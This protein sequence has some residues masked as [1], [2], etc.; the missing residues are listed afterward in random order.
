MPRLSPAA[1]AAALVWGAS[2]WA[3]TDPTATATRRVLIQEAQRASEAGDHARALAS[4]EQAGRMEMTASLRRFIAEEQAASGLLAEA[5]GSAD[6][7]VREGRASTLPGSAEHV[8]ACQVMVDALGL[9]AGRVLVRA[10]DAPSDLSVR[11]AGR[12]HAR[13][14]W[15]TAYVVT[16][17]PVEVTAEARGYRPF[18]ALITV[19]EGETREVRV[20]LQALT[21]TVTPG[22]R[23][24]GAGPWAVVGAG[25]AMLGTGAVFFALRGAALDRA[26]TE[27]M[28]PSVAECADAPS[29]AAW[30]RGAAEHERAATWA[31]LSGVSFALG[32]AATAGG[33]LWYILAPREAAPRRVV[34]LA[35]TYGGA[36]VS[37]GGSL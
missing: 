28:R 13:T 31:A 17:G 10:T 9:R 22:T 7:C 29:L 35:L 16:P 20:V 18:H 8:A 23:G 34:S 11:I 1:I 26:A 2:A 36:F 4:A 15:N 24:P 12:D 21:R 14:L 6:L 37:F 33:L 19:R 27:C 3:Q 32:A 30:Q 5:L 25:V